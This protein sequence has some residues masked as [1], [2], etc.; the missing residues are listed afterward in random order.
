[1]ATLPDQDGSGWQWLDADAAA[2]SLGKAKRTLRL[3]AKDGRIERRYG[4]DSRVLYRVD[5]GEIPAAQDDGNEVVTNDDL[6]P[7]HGSE[8]KGG[9]EWRE[10]YWQLSEQNATLIR[11]MEAKDAELRLTREKIDSLLAMVLTTRQ[12]PM[13][14]DGNGGG[15]A[16]TVTI[17]DVNGKRWWRFWR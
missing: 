15:N 6:P 17:R 1:M 10:A 13:A 4:D 11:Q 16:A 2:A 12:L 7:S 9:K 8:D 3:W 14:M 5:V